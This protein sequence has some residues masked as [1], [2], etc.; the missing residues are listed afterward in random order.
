MDLSQTV[1]GKRIDEA[2]RRGGFT[3][4]EKRSA[5]RWTTCACGNVTD[6]IPRCT[7]GSPE[8][9]KLSHLGIQFVNAVM[10]DAFAEASA[11]LEAIELRARDVAGGKQ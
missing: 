10:E 8:D 11:L 2:E 6:D 3:D 5:D 1:W 9:A 7:D 4:D